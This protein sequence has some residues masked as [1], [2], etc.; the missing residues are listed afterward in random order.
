M[1][2]RASAHSFKTVISTLRRG[3]GGWGVLD[4]D[5][6]K[7][8]QDWEE[9]PR[10]NEIWTKICTAAERL[11]DVPLDLAHAMDFVVFVLEAKGAAGHVDKLAAEIASLRKSYA[12]EQ[13]R[14]K[15]K[16][17]GHV[18]DVS[19]PRELALILKHAAHAAEILHRLNESP[20]RH[21]ALRS[22][23][24]GS[25]QRTLFIRD[26]SNLVHDLTGRWLDDEVADLTEIAF[27][28]REITVDIVRAARRETTRAGRAPRGG[29]HD[30]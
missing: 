10:S 25:R 20:A 16:V 19:S 15:K 21:Q 6:M 11:E 17:I 23:H 24:D 7:M 28:P 26:V 4:P 27:P 9:H 14:F 13:E 30:H 1:D 18:Q 5:K 2:T 12:T 22:D 8:L 3:Y 29:A